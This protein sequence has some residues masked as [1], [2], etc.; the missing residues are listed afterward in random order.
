MTE[1]PWRERSLADLNELARRCAESCQPIARQTNVTLITELGSLPVPVAV[2]PM[3]LHEVM[4]GYLS[5]AIR[6]SG[7]GGRVV[8][9]VEKDQANQAHVIVQDQG[10]GID[11]KILPVIFVPLTGDR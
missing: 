6:H 9:R 11:P 10:S 2:N 8:L 5:N 1:I 7:P 3:H 4:Q